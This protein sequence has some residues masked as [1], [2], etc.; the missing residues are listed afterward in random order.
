M[1]LI[2]LLAKEGGVPLHILSKCIA[3]HAALLM[4]LYYVKIDPETMKKTMADA[5]S[6]IDTGAQAE[7]ARYLRS[8]TRKA[9][10][11]VAN[12]PAGVT[13]LDRSAPASWMVVDTGICPVGGQLCDRG[14]S[15]LPAGG[16]GP[17]PG[18]PRKRISRTAG[19]ARPSGG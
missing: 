11:F 2:T 8:E 17:V 16:H 5:A 12:D 19:M 13:A 6:K 18:G 3:G 14:G 9:E 15:K 7:F 1:T 4:T 10:G